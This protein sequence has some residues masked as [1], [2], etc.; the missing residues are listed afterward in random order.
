MKKLSLILAAVSILVTGCSEP[1]DSSAQVSAS[2][3]AVADPAVVA[4]QQ[5]LN[6]GKSR[7]I[8]CT[9][10][11]GLQ[12]ISN[13][14]MYPSLAGRDAA[15]LK[16]LLVAYRTG[17]KVNPLMSPQAK[18]LSDADVDLLAKYFSVLPA[19]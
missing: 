14:A 3:T 19:K 10:C 15:E 11:H 17:E 16:Q 9:A 8:S 4:K 6:Q 1:T 2:A 12:G 18:A 7:A 5:L 13:V